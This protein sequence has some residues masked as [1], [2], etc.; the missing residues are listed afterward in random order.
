MSRARAE[1]EQIAILSRQ[2]DQ[3]LTEQQ[4]RR[5]N[6]STSLKEMLEYVEDTQKGDHLL[7]RVEKPA[8]P[9][10]D[11]HGDEGWCSFL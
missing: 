5:Q 6:L 2:V 7:R 8:V 11:P 10:V 9:L 4:V 1:H 3:L